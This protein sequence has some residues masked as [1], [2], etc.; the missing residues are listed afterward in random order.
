M[1]PFYICFDFET[2]GLRPDYHEA[3]QVAGKAYN[4]ETLQP[5]PVELGGEF[6]SYMKPEYFDRLEPGAMKVNKISIETL[7]A[8]PEA[9]QVWL[10][11]IDW[12][13]SF[14]KKGKGSALPIACGK[15]IRHFDLKFVHELNLKYSPT[16]EKTQ[17]FNNRR[18]IDLEDMLWLWFE[19]D[20]EFRSYSMDNLREYT[21]MPTEGAHDALVDVRQTGMVIMDIL[22][23]HRNIRSRVLK[24]GR[25]LVEFRNRYR[26]YENPSPN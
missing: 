2:G 24:D 14:S 16:K 9:K 21:G 22:N 13:K 5:V 18:C 10:S 20:R 7:K 3:V 23:L 1:K 4:G 17:I 26:D 8:A 19:N 15:N 12:T 11:F 6:V 25:K